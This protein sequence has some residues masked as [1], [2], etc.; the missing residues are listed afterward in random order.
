[1]ANNAS[2]Y[3]PN[4]KSS[5]PVQVFFSGSCILVQNKSTGYTISAHHRWL[6]RML[7]WCGSCFLMVGYLST[8]LIQ[9]NPNLLFLTAFFISLNPI[10]YF[11]YVY[12]IYKSVY[13]L[14][15]FS[16]KLKNYKYVYLK[17]FV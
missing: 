6:M 3:F 16:Y 11:L 2:G 9:P 12:I 17:S 5:L 1:M 10:I 13:N 14:S 15:F 7:H 4:T 8:T